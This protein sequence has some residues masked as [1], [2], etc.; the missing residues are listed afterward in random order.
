MR[1]FSIVREMELSLRENQS[2][3]ATCP[4]N[5]CSIPELDSIFD[6]VGVVKDEGSEVVLREREISSFNW[7]REGE[8]RYTGEKMDSFFSNFLAFAG[9]GDEVLRF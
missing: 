7:F 4:C 6:M 5:Y 1:D 9:G 2:G 8:V 3:S